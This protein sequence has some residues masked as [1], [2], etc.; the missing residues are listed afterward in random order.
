M[1]DWQHFVCLFSCPLI[2]CI[3]VLIFSKKPN[4][5]DAIPGMASLA[6]LYFL[7]VMKGQLIQGEVI[8][9]KLIYASNFI[10]HFN[11]DPMGLLFAQLAAFLW[12][13]SSIYSVG[14]L[15][16]GG[17]KHQ[18]RFASFFSLCIFSTLGVALS[19][20]LITFFIFYEL[21]TLST[22]P[23]VMHLQSQEA[24]K[25]SRQ[26][27]LYTLGAGQLLLIAIIWLQ[28][29]G[30]G[31]YFGAPGRIY[32]LVASQP[33]QLTII[34]MLFL[35]G[36]GVKAAIFPLHSWLPSAMVA[37]TPVSAL[38]HA[39]A[40]VKSGVFG[41]GRVMGF[42]FGSYALQTLHLDI[43]VG[44]LAAFTILFASVRALSE[45]QMKKILAY[46][47]ISQ[48]SY[49]VLGFAIG[50][51]L[52][53]FGS[54]FHIVAHAF[55]KITLFFCAGSIQIQSG[56]TDVTKMSG[57][58]R[59][60]PITFGFFS[61][62]ALSMIGT[63]LL[64][65]FISK[66]SF[67]SG[68]LSSPKHIIFALVYIVSSLLNIGYFFPIIYRSCFDQIPVGDQ[69]KEGSWKLVLPI[70]VTGLSVITF[71]L[72]PDLIFSFYTLSLRASMGFLS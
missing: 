3:L 28:Q 55:M 33:V 64:V 25:A 37:P 68:S 45:T 6:L 27:L 43:L 41:I 15:R 39:V 53:I 44:G 32:D 47:T 31:P 26:Y 58:A 18:T 2:A 56:Q 54:L 71:G 10:V 8:H 40:V 21:L 65:G 11:V 60:M 38:L 19:S 70:F 49:I 62:S 67:I 20:N 9:W 4:L 52:S 72:F 42:I 29:L 63:P 61:I 30:I 13:C 7:Q 12:L 48:L 23:L 17:Y 57:Y 5:R 50:T 59:Q 34:F 35:I 24:K 46:S 66:W 14:Y 36:F 1:I 16:G 69:I 22:Y 51:Q